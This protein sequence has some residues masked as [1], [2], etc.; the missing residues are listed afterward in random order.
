MNEEEKSEPPQS[1]DDR[2]PGKNI[3]E[4]TNMPES[5]QTLKPLN[6]LNDLNDNMEVHKHPH[7]VTHKKKW[8]EYLLEFLMLFLAVFLGFLAENIREHQVE[9]ERAHGLVASLINDLQHDTA[10]LNMLVKMRE[11]KTLCYDSLR[12]LLQKSPESYDHNLFYRLIAKSESYFKFSQASGTTSQLKNAGYLRYFSDNDLIKNISNYEFW[13][14]DYLSDERIE[15]NWLN[16]KFTDFV[17][18]NLDNSIIPAMIREH[19]FPEGTGVTF[20]KPDGLQNLRALVEELSISNYLMMT[21]Q[22]PRV[23]RE[24]EKL[25]DYLHKKYHLE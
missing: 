18:F 3:P 17:A 21:L 16:E 14:Q 5:E 22:A 20:N 4:E 11:Q 13:I 25:M 2:P 12:E 23:K 9:K 6:E 15:L 10:Q 8:A 1:T 24:S 7:H 19:R